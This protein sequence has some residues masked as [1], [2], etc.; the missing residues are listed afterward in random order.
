MS[1]NDLSFIKIATR[2][3]DLHV[4]SSNACSHF[5]FREI[6]MLSLIEHFVAEDPNFF[7]QINCSVVWAVLSKNTHDP[8]INNDNSQ[9]VTHLGFTGSDSLA[10]SHRRT[11]ILP[12]HK[13]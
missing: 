6:V 9:L 2:I 5:I 8:K 1:P 12:A 7:S 10:Y 3:R 13:T 11:V 4:I